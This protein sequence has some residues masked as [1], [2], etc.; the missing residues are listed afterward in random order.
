VIVA[1]ASAVVEFLRGGPQSRAVEPFLLDAGPI[2][3]PGILDAEV[4]QAVRKLVRLGTMDD[5]RGQTFMQTLQVMPLNRHLLTPL[6]P[7]MWALRDNLT[8]Y[9]AAYIALAEALRCPMITF[10]ERLPSA[11]GHRADIVVP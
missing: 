9:D 4:L 7:R 10:D 11:P 5:A 8:A 2:H 6:L 3:V 1:D